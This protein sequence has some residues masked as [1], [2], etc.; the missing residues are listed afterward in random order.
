M[1]E[2]EIVTTTDEH[3]EELALTMSPEDIAECWAASHLKPY[4]ALKRSLMYTNYPQTGLVDGRVMAIWGVGK[5]TQLSDSGIPWMLTSHIVEDNFRSFLRYS[6]DLL[7]TMK[8]EALV[9]ENFVDSRNIISIKWLKW[10]GF[11]IHDALPYGPDNMLFHRFT[12]EN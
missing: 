12:M 10:L 11:T 9:F 5:L 4:E 6:K 2:Y 8:K 7:N 3:V 1:T